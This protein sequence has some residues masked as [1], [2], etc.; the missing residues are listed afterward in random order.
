[1]EKGAILSK[2]IQD[3]LSGVDVVKIF[4]AQERET[5]KIHSHL[6]DLKRSDIKQN[7]IST[8]SSEIMSLLGIIGGF[9]VLWFGGINII[10]GNFTIGGY[11]AF[12]G[13]LAKLYGP[14]QN[15]AMMGL[16]LQPAI[17]ALNR[18]T[19]FFKFTREEVDSR[20]K[21]EI[22]GIK[23]NIEFKKV[24]FSYGSKN[25]LEDIGFK[26]NKTDKVLIS[27][28]NGS[29]KNYNNQAITRFV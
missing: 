23:E 28:P 18:V 8:F 7:I 9:I 19:E 10:K 21:T 24:T 6:E 16:S 29:G 26:I 13:Y 17:T 5:N 11:I 22:S 1:M 27:G 2:K 12:T 4:T 3:S 14:T 25:A 15:I 20:K